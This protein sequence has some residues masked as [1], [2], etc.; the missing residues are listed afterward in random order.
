[1]KETSI[2]I[3]LILAA[4]LPGAY[5]A[6]LALSSAGLTGIVLA[7]GSAMLAM[8]I[9]TALYAAMTTAMRALGWLAK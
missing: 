2:S 7:I 9:A 8:V 5:L 6:W 1:M 4:A 3:L